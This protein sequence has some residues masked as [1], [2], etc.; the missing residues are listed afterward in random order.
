MLQIISFPTES[1]SSLGTLELTLDRSSQ[2]LIS[3]RS[4]SLLTAL[5]PQSWTCQTELNR[6]RST[7][8]HISN[9]ENAPESLSE[10]FSLSHTK[11]IHH[12]PGR[13]WS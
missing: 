3:L 7:G 4:Q 12:S 9:S 13:A 11:V 2:V 8:D 5:H 1:P 6:A 10:I